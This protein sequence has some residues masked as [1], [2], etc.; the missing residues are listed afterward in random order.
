MKSEPVEEAVKHG[1]GNN[2]TATVTSYEP[3]DNIP[4]NR[5]PEKSHQ[6]IIKV[7]EF[8]RS[9]TSV[10]FEN[11]QSPEEAKRLKVEP[12]A[13]GVEYKLSLNK[14]YRI[15]PTGSPKFM[16]ALCSYACDTHPKMK[17]HLYR[18]RPQKYKCPYCDHRKYP[19]YSFFPFVN[20][21]YRKEMGTSV[22]PVRG[23]PSPWI[24]L[25]LLTFRHISN[26]MNVVITSAWTSP[27]GMPLPC[28]LS[29]YFNIKL[30]NY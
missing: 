23:S 27:R 6:M 16:C 7:P 4:A 21:R 30:T 13:P 14:L 2:I 3:R 1:F 26:E 22:A 24:Q 29:L 9:I 20:H 18:H 8:K 15:N 5:Q 19:R 28:I 25:P 12:D 10:S 17:H 11:S